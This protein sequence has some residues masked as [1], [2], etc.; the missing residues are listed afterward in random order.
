VAY[1]RAVAILVDAKATS[2]EQDKNRAATATE[3]LLRVNCR[4]HTLP[5]IGFLPPS[6]KFQRNENL[7]HDRKHAGCVPSGAAWRQAFGVRA[8][9]GALHEGHLSLVR[10]AK[11]ECDVAAASIFVNPAQFGAGEDLAKY[12][13]R[14]D[15]DR[16]L[17]ER[18]G[19]DLLF[20]AI[21]GG[22]VSGGRSDLGYGGGAE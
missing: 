14:F 2:S 11:A 12:P 18:A 3:G 6:K 9:M 20:C 15:L 22:N 19:V 16:E 1:G 10:A 4:A 21:G 5:S 17:L 7:Q 8:T 13:R